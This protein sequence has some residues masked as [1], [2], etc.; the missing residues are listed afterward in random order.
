MVDGDAARR[1]RLAAALEKKS[2]RLIVAVTLIRA[3]AAAGLFGGVG[4]RTAGVHDIVLVSVVILIAMGTLVYVRAGVGAGVEMGVG[5]VMCFVG[6]ALINGS[7]VING[8]L[9]LVAQIVKKKLIGVVEGIVAVL[10]GIKS[11]V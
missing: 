8:K 3:V 11:V 4:I 9:I 5:V 6:I 1:D 7:V 10:R 2:A